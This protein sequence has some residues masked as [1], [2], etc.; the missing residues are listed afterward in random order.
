MG[1]QRIFVPN[2][3]KVLIVED[4]EARKVYFR[5]SLAHA[6][7]HLVL[8]PTDAIQL[9]QLFSYDVI[10]LDHDLGLV[11]EGDTNTGMQVVNWICENP[12]EVQC[13]ILVHSSNLERSLEM[14]ARLIDKQKEAVRIPFE[15]LRIDAPST[16]SDT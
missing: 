10:L 8:R 12:N 3:A 5:S 9:L 11:E 13:P 16:T 6:E 15:R 4:Q 14:V 2:R 1:P 7:L